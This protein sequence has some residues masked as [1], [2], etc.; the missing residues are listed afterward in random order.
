MGLKDLWDTL[1]HTNNY[2]SLRKTSEKETE[3]LF[4]EIMT[5]NF[6]NL[7]KEMDLQIQPQ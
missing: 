5:R 3:R 1:K 4:E 6:P 2:G 7:R